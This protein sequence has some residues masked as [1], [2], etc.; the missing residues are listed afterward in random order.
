MIV[1]KKFT[2]TLVVGALADQKT[3]EMLS[4]ICVKKVLVDEIVFFSY[5]PMCCEIS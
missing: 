1:K 3:L 4:K 5:L 2:I